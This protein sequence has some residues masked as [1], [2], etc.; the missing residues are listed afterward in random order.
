[1]SILLSFSIA[2]ANWPDSACAEQPSQ[3]EMCSAFCTWK[4]CAYD[5]WCSC[6]SCLPMSYCMTACTFITCSSNSCC[7]CGYCYST[8]SATNYSQANET[9]I[10]SSI[11]PGNYS[12]SCGE[13]CN[14]TNAFCFQDQCYGSE[15]CEGK[16]D[17]VQDCD[18]CFCGVCL[19]DDDD[20]E[21]D[22]SVTNTMGYQPADSQNNPDPFLACL[23][24]AAVALIGVTGL[25]I[26]RIYKPKYRQFGSS[27]DQTA[28]CVEPKKIE[29]QTQVEKLDVFF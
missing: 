9:N 2:K 17:D 25:L 27:I 15:M 29:V 19:H 22:K 5:H 3:T 11:F 1:M 10:T 24:L 4:D 16:C 28:V 23:V 7:N 21:T 13:S 8:S 14:I 12:S 26:V 6:G 20:V 18:T